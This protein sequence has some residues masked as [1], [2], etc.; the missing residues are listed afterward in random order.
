MQNK[1]ESPRC[2]SPTPRFKTPLLDRINLEYEQQQQ[3]QQRLHQRREHLQTPH[4]DD[5]SDSFCGIFNNCGGLFSIIHTAPFVKQDAT[6]NFQEISCIH[7][8][9]AENLME[10][11]QW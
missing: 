4:N 9:I 7:N 5:E 2:T 11:G 1:I 3:Q 10:E 8:S 6:G